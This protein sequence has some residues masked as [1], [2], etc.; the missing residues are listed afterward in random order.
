MRQDSKIYSTKADAKCGTIHGS[1]I[2]NDSLDSRDTSSD[3]WKQE[4]SRSKGEVSA[5]IEDKGILEGKKAVI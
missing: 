3:D 2:E 5:L 4:W 1:D